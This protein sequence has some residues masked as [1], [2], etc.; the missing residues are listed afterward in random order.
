MPA[1]D[2]LRLD[3]VLFAVEDGDNR[4]RQVAIGVLNVLR[5]PRDQ[6]PGQVGLVAN[7][8][9]VL[10]ALACRG[11]ARIDHRHDQSK[12]RHGQQHFDKGKTVLDCGLRIA[13]FGFFSV[14][15]VNPQSAIRNPQFITLFIAHQLHHLVTRS[16]FPEDGN[17]HFHYLWGS[18]WL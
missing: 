10:H 1:L 12:D 13:D 7:D 18:A 2:S 3:L 17:A 8:L 16:L 5:Q 15:L 11:K 6:C 9:G 4:L 14:C